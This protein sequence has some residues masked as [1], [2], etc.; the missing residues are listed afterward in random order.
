MSLVHAP[1][2]HIPHTVSALDKDMPTE[3]ELR[4][5]E[6]LKKVLIYVPAVSLL[7]GASFLESVL[8]W[9]V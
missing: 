9:E 7:P 1:L 5:T 4:E 6:V 3:D 8:V 2:S